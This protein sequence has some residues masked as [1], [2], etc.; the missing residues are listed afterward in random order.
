MTRLL[1]LACAVLAVSCAAATPAE[2]ATPPPSPSPTPDA[3]PDYGRPGPLGRYD[4]ETVPEASG[5]AASRRNPGVWWLMSDGH[6][7]SVWAIRSTGETIGHIELLGLRTDDTEAL[8]VAPCGDRTCVYVG[9]IGDNDVRRTKVQVLRFAEPDLAAG[10]PP[11]PPPTEVVSLRYPDG[12]FNAEALLVDEDGTPY[13]VTKQPGPPQLFAAPAYADGTL[14]ALGPVP[15][16]RTFHDLGT[17]VTGGDSRPGHVLLRTYGEA[18]EFT[19]PVEDAPLG[20]FP[21]WPSR[22]VPSAL[23]L[24]S[25]AIAYTPDGSGYL[26]LSEGDPTI[27]SVERQAGP[28]PR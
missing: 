9:D 23:E 18:V 20:G 27:W 12:G 11:T 22:V 21:S 15:I 24:G 10:I 4:T 26:T 19:A 5:L 2:H 8:A 25:E 1:L 13:I 3:A 6:S 16:P 7:N 14:V 28:E 17:L